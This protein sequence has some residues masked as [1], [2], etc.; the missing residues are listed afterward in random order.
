MTR[1][2]PTLADLQ[3]Q[4]ATMLDYLR[5]RLSLEDWHGVR[6]AAADLEVIEGKLRVVGPREKGRAKAR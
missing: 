6:D 5:L 3:R 1:K 2:P 4:R